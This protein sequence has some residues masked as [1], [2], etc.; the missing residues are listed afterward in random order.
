MEIQAQRGLATCP[1]YL[2]SLCKGR[3]CTVWLGSRAVNSPTA[4]YHVLIAIALDSVFK[5]LQGVD[6]QANNYGT[7]QWNM[8]RT[9][10]THV[11]VGRAP[12]LALAFGSRCRVNPGACPPR[13]TGPSQA[14]G[15]GAGAVAGSGPRPLRP[16]PSKAG[17]VGAV[18]HCLYSGQRLVCLSRL[19]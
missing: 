5:E 8:R 1:R 12:A 2:V 3:I 15:V 11:Q 19:W 10:G 18:G 16:A 9:S 17:E 13:R 7:W 6:K 14:A 4:L